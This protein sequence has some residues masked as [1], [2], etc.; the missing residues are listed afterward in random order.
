MIALPSEFRLTLL[1]EFEDARL[2]PD[3]E[4]INKLI[5]T[6]RDAVQRVVE[7][8]WKRRNAIIE[9]EASRQQQGGDGSAPPMR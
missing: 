8:F 6:G 3:P 7:T 4:I 9:D 2:E 5:I 1:Q